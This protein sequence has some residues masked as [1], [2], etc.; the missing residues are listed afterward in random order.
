[1][2]AALH[3]TLMQIELRRKLEFRCFQSLTIIFGLGTLLTYIP[4][5]NPNAEAWLKEHWHLHIFTM[6]CTPIL[7][8]ASE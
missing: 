6:I 3:E 7:G 5:H 2:I 1:M 4:I 8:G